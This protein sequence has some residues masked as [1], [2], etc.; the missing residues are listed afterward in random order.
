MF[1]QDKWHKVY[2]LALQIIHQCKT[3][4][5]KGKDQSTKHSWPKSL[6]TANSI[7]MMQNVA[8][9]SGFKAELK[10]PTYKYQVSNCSYD[11]TTPGLFRF[12]WSA[13]AIGDTTALGA[14]SIWWNQTWLQLICRGGGRMP[15]FGHA[16]LIV[17]VAAEAGLK[18]LK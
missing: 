2:S 13:A 7:P 11:S 14:S 18:H 1:M 4:E 16:L 3:K 10:N 17:D 12:L 9:W 8:L 15:S 5:R 6:L